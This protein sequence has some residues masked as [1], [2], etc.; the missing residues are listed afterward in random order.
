MVDRSTDLSQPLDKLG[1]D[2]R[3]KFD[4]DYLRGNIATDLLDRITGGVTFESNKLMKFHGIYQQDDRDIRDERRKQKLEPAHTFMVRIRLPGGVCTPE[5]WLKMDELARTHGGNT[6]RLTTRQ[7]FQFHWVVK[8]AIRPTIEGLH[9]VLLDTIAACGDDSRGVMATADPADS[10]VHAEV[11]ALAKQLSDHVIPK[12]RAYHEIWYGEERVATSEDEE[13]FYGRTY[14]P[15]KFKIGF[16]IP[17]SND[18]DI[19]TQDLGFIAIVGKDG[20]EGFNVGIGG[21]MGR[22]DNEPRTYPRLANVVGFIPKERL[23]ACADAVMGVQRDYGNRAERPRARFKYTIDDKGLDFIKS[24]IEQRMG[25]TFGPARPFAFESN[26]DRYGW[27][28]TD[29]GQFNYGL[30]IQS[31]RV[32]DLPGRS[33]MSGLRAIAKVHNGHFRLTP[34]QNL[35]IAGVA[36]ENR[37]QIEALLAEH[38]LDGSKDGSALRLNSIAC[39][40]FPTCPL[41]MAEAERYLP[42][43]LTKIEAI[44]ETN[45]LSREPITIRMSGC[46]NGCSRPYVAEIALTGR[47]PGKY[48]LWLGGGFHG[49]RLNRPIAE[50]IGE[51]R[52]LEILSEQFAAYARNRRP[53]ER[54]GDFF[55]RTVD[56]PVALQHA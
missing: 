5:Q 22:T 13:P 12:T 49:E 54:F 31:G 10:E 32:S 48:D 18:V 37:P 16:A 20:V 1:P 2:E 55:T 27:R 50:N 56:Q 17:P 40:A 24:E 8:E 33:I 30:F 15:R 3:L 45:G 14:L 4:S 34:N 19:Y 38:G 23:I 26:G 36:P 43:L 6:L 7:T 42:D 21:G 39:V 53:G 51:A 46:P 52:I 47:A 11:A 41:A 25:A 35:I 44:L 9:E 29:R 28:K